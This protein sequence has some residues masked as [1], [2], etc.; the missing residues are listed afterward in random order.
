VQ[1]FRSTGTSGGLIFTRTSSAYIKERCSELLRLVSEADRAVSDGDSDAAMRLSLVRD[2][3][4]ATV[5]PAWVRDHE[6]DASLAA[7]R[8]AH[9]PAF[10]ASDMASA[11]D[12]LCSEVL[13]ARFPAETERPPAERNSG[14]G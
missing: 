4:L 8:A 11:F 6:D 14:W 10:T 9:L 5:G 13:R 12:R 3:V 7:L 1:Y 2:L